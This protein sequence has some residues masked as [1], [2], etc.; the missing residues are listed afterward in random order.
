[1]GDTTVSN[2]IARVGADASPMSEE[3]KKAQNTIL[4]FKDESLAALKSFGLPHISSTNLVEAIQS[5]QRVVVDFTQE[6]GESLEQFQQRVRTV[7]EEA[8]IDITEYE[9]VLTDA[10]QV[11]AE[12]AKGA[13]KSFQAAEVESQTYTSETITKF[14]ELKESLAASFAAIGDESVGMATKVAA[15][16]DIINTALPELF[17][18]GLAVMAMD[19]VGEWGKSIDEFAAET[20]DAE[21]SFHASMGSMSEDAEKFTKNLSDSWGIDQEALEK[22]MGK[23]YL[24]NQ[25]MGF[26][27]EQSEEMSQNMTKLSYSLGKLRGEDPGVVFDSLQRGL[28]GE[29]RGLKDLGISVTTTDLKN[30]ALSEGIIKQGQTMTTAQTALMAYQEIMKKAGNQIDYYATQ[31]DTL[32]NKQAKLNADWEDMKRQLSEALVPALTAFKGVIVSVADDLIKVGDAV[33]VAIRYITVFA[34]DVYSAIQD[35]MALNFGQISTDWNNNYNSVMNSTAALGDATSA[36]N[37]NAGATN[38]QTAAQKKLNKAVNANTMSFDQLHNITNSGAAGALAQADAVNNLA[39]ALGN[40]KTSGMGNLTGNQSKGIVI[41]ISF[42][43]PPFPP[44]TPPPAV[45]AGLQKYVENAKQMADDWEKNTAKDA[46]GVGKAISGV[47]PAYDTTASS[48]KKHLDDMSS[49]TEAYKNGTT[50]SLGD[51]MKELGKLKPAF[52]TSGELIHTWSLSAA[53][54][55][56]AFASNSERYMSTFASEFKSAWSQA[57]SATETMVEGWALRVEKAFSSAVGSAMSSIGSLASAAGKTISNVGSSIA[58][59]AENHKTLLAVGGIAGLTI[60]SGGTDLIAGGIAAAGEALAGIGSGLGAAAL[61]GVAKFATGG[62]VTSPTLGV[63]GEA[64]PEAVIPLSEIGSVLNGLAKSTT[65]TSHS[66]SSQPI[67]ITV[68]LDGR[69]VA[70]TLYPYTTNEANRL[71]KNIGYDI[72]NNYPR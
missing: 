3:L 17:A 51:V 1:M 72:S 28:E 38:N 59:W 46:Q 9:K 29:T 18:L 58:N 2:I 53:Q 20:Q 68:Q 5:G 16:G 27:P 8:G 6:A 70:R 14:N 4:T 45:T 26:S 34:E 37:S 63:F 10:N 19:K 21:R 69:T 56:S 48:V 15:A 30:L 42:K 71:G 22:M 47:S 61:A 43:V 31:S 41:P 24:N 64:G 13:V 62:I 67:Y 54:D 12:F 23:E 44:I 40:L 11:H 39:S 66:A 52:N 49:Y 55:L 33:A 35:I 57:L 32:S 36:A 50:V 65:N 60:A 25:M 7:F